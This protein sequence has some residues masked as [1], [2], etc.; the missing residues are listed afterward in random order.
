MHP[1]HREFIEE[2]KTEVT[3]TMADEQQ[4]ERLHRAQLQG[5]LR[6]LD[7]QEENLIDLAADGGLSTAKV[8][9]MFGCSS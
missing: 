8:R 3:A 6:R 9:L 2:V 5:Q 7:T 4:A 1:I